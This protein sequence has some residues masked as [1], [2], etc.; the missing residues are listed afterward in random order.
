MKV[1][2]MLLAAA[3]VVSTAHVVTSQDRARP[4]DE[5]ARR[6]QI[7]M[8]VQEICPS[9]GNKLGTHG[10]PIKVRIGQETLFMCCKGCLQGKIN[11]QHWATIH[12]NFAKAQRICPIMKKQLPQRNKPL[13]LIPVRLMLISD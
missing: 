7:R 13:H 2:R 1:A 6:D 9:T 11:P 5:Q 10:A 4:E 3:L 8:S 12:N